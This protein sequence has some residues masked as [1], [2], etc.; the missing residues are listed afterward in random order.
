MKENCRNIYRLARYMSGLD[1]MTAS[2]E[3]GISY[4]TL[5]YYELGDIIPSSLMAKNMAKLYKARWL[6]YYHLALNDD[7]GKQILERP[8]I[9]DIFL[10]NEKAPVERK[11]PSRARKINLV[12]L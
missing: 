11:A 5:Q 12:R 3:L 1:M 4:R 8:R 2:I 6:L 7:A 10:Y 9:E